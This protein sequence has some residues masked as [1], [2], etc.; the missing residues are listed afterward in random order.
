MCP[1]VHHNRELNLKMEFKEPVSFL[2]RGQ[3]RERGKFVCH[4]WGGKVTAI[5]ETYQNLNLKNKSFS[6]SWTLKSRRGEEKEKGKGGMALFRPLH[7][8]CS[9]TG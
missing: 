9:I 1:G 7:K 6:W 8:D 5:I 3:K 4:G 2:G